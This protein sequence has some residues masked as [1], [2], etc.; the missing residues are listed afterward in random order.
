MKKTFFLRILI[1]AIITFLMYYVTL[2]AINLHSFGFYI[3]ILFIIIV[4]KLTSVIEI[5]SNAKKIFRKDNIIN[6]SKRTLILTVIVCGVFVFIILLNF[7]FSPLFMSGKYASRINILE[8]DDFVGE[9]REVDFNKIPLLDKDSS[10]KLGDRVM[11]QM[12]ELVSQF[13]VSSLYTQINYNDEIIRVT[14]LEYASG[15]KWLTNRKEGI[16]GYIKVNSVSGKSELVKLEKGMKYA[17]SALFN[18]NLH[19]KLRFE[20]PTKIFAGYSFELDNEGNPYWT[21]PTIKYTAV[22]LL[23]EIEGLI[24]FNPITGNSQYYDVKDVPSWVDQV[25]SASLITSQVDD[26]GTYKN[27]FINSVFGQKGVVQTT[28]GYNYLI[29]DD[30]VYMYTGI[31]SINSDESNIGFII[32]NLRTKETKLYNVP[33]AEEYSAMDSAEGQVQQMNYKS[34]FPLLINLNNR[35]TYLISLKDRAGLVKM[36]A[37]VDVEDYQKVVVSDASSGVEEAAKN[38]LK[39]VNIKGNSN[40]TQEKVIVIESITNATIDGMTYYYIVDDENQKYKVSIKTN[41]LLPFMKKGDKLEI[42]YYGEKDI[43]DISNIR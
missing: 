19:R 11:G 30:D 41:D 7:I 35:P 33:G 43:I 31:T 26:W 15:I 10:S 4:Y 32:T 13:E 29:Q 24:I 20:Y 2:P 21:I 8:T 16:K 25:Y 37:F 17:P 22:G 6:S 18:E 23:E 34:T 27:G 3:F 36:Y 42:V 9:I 14:P 40:L 39:Q 1:T 28:T 38:Y 12:S 5:P